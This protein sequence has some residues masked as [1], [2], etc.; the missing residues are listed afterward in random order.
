[1]P[2][3]DKEILDRVMK[4]VFYPDQEITKQLNEYRVEYQ[5]LQ[6][7]MMSVKPQIESL[8]K[9]KI[10][11]KQLTQEVSQLNEQLEVNSFKVNLI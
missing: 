7:E 2:A 10:L 3:V 4:R 9:F 5:V 6:E 1:M 11:N 8:E